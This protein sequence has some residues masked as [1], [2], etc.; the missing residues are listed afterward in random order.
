V[1][2]RGIAAAGE[3]SV[4][5]VGATDGHARPLP[6]VHLRRTRAGWR[7]ALPGPALAGIYPI[8]VES[9]GRR[10]SR[11]TWLF[12]AYPPGAAGGRSYATRRA[13][14]RG[15]VARLPGHQVLV[16]LRFWKQTAIDRRDRRLNALV[17]VA[18]APRGDARVADRRGLFLTLARDGPHGG[19]RCLRATVAPY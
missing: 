5:L 12:R 6:P 2:V 18:Y 4:V 7:G 9:G 1:L 17:V 19:W 8:V 14:A 3:A 15:W 13:A 10:Y 11:P 16:A